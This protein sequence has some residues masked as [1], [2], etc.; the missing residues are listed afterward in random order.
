M[1]SLKILKM[2]NPINWFEKNRAISLLVT[3]T[4]LSLIF[5]ISSIQFTTTSSSTGYLSY[6]YHF[7]AFSYLSL[8]LLITLTKGKPSRLLIFLG[9]LIAFAYSISDEIH[10]YFIPGRASAIKDIITNSIGIIITSIAY[11]NHCKCKKK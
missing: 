3:L 9:I 4:I 8:F 7:T 11:N 1:H 6:I 2:G 10:Q 5:Y